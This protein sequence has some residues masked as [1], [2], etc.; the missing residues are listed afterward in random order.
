MHGRGI[1]LFD[2]EKSKRK[3]EVK[4]A[5]FLELNEFW[6]GL[7]EARVTKL[8]HPEWKERRLPS[9]MSN[10]YLHTVM[11]RL[12][13]GRG[14]LRYVIHRRHDSRLQKCRYGCSEKEDVCHVI[15]NCKK[16]ERKRNLLKRRCRKMNLE[17]DMKTL[18]CKIDLQ[19][20]VE[21]LIGAFLNA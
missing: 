19:D 18:F 20:D 11:H 8:I 17:Y 13:L 4:R 16:N 15:F 1:N 14:P 7:S 12:A 21:A 6:H 5:M 9:F 10:R 2:C 3:S